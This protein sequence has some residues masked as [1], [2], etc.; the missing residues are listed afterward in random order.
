MAHKIGDYVHYKYSNYLRYATRY[1]SGP[2]VNWSENKAAQ[3]FLAQHKLI[4]AKAKNA[5]TFENREAIRQDLEDK[6]NFMFSDTDLEI[7]A[8][9]G[10]GATLKLQQAVQ[11]ILLN[12]FNSNTIINFDNAS[13]LDKNKSL[14]DLSSVSDELREKISKALKTKLAD[15]N[16][17]YTTYGAISK[18]LDILAQVFFELTKNNSYK[19]NNQFLTAVSSF[20]TK[21]TKEIQE[22]ETDMKNFSK[23][24][25]IAENVHYNFKIKN[26][27]FVKDLQKLMDM[28]KQSYLNA[29]VGRLGEILPLAGDYAK[30]SALAS[31][32][33]DIDVYIQ[34]LT[35]SLPTID[36]LNDGA[37]QWIGETERSNK[38]LNKNNFMLSKKDK[39]SGT[40]IISFA[41]E[42]SKISYTQDKVDI[43]I[44]LDGIGL[45]NIKASV[46]NVNFEALNE[47]GFGVGLLSGTSVITRI[48]DYWNFTNHYLNVSANEGRQSDDI[49]PS[50]SLLI[51][52]HQALKMTLAYY[53]LV[54]GE[55]SQKRGSSVIKQMDKAE[56][57]IVNDNSQKKGK[58]KVYFI[59][60]I[61]NNSL[62]KDLGSIILKIN[63]SE[64]IP[65]WGNNFISVSNTKNST[66]AYARIANIIAQ[67]QRAKLEI[68]ISPKIFTR[69]I[70]K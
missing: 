36:I 37:G 61:I 26:R 59:D 42:T 30:T 49:Q 52:A 46:K 8:Q 53:A 13:I 6:L 45:K 66:L 1:P 29:L 48:Q 14:S 4:Q 57:L 19:N 11:N 7:D 65:N 5:R 25:R 18:R 43:T 22:I 24:S 41:G 34:Q 38:L 70:T 9:F 10:P 21:Y 62:S 51:E 39:Q 12:Y 2:Q 20:W 56:I 44:D 50:Y 32:L 35:Q 68:A 64:D 33:N 16:K 63:E 15:T 67:M 55:W 69:N 31:G 60:E 17:D 54:G 40:D 3:I 27:T 47:T 23:E 28:L 58:Y